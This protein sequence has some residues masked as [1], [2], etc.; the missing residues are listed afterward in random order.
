[1]PNIN[2]EF[3]WMLFTWPESIRPLLLALS[4]AGVAKSA[5]VKAE[6][7]RFDCYFL[8]LNCIG[9]RPKDRP[10]LLLALSTAGMAK[11][12]G[13]KAEF[14][15][16]DCYILGLNFVECRPKDRPTLRSS[17]V[18]IPCLRSRRNEIFMIGL[19]GGIRASA[20]VLMHEYARWPLA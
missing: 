15:R 5:G 2:I 14:L 1:M 10:T 13:G 17:S 19:H 7:L 4:T 20:Y 3:G 18:G 9:C 12:A 11:S 6:F 16:F 8:S